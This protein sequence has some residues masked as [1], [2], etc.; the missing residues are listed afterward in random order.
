MIS[1][2][3]Q[4]SKS[5]CHYMTVHFATYS[6]NLGGIRTSMDIVCR[7]LDFVI[8]FDFSLVHIE[9][10]VEFGGCFSNPHLLLCWW[11]SNWHLLLV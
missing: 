2:D 9:W 10:S 11:A 4:N 3:Q 5:Y 8:K 6:G 1:I 7:L